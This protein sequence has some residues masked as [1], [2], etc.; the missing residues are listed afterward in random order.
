MGIIKIIQKW[1]DSHFDNPKVKNEDKQHRVRFQKDRLF[2]LS[3]N[4]DGGSK[5][6]LPN[7]RNLLPQD[8]GRRRF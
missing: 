2:E 8:F 4:Q 3:A 6:D 1:L 7:I 5:Q